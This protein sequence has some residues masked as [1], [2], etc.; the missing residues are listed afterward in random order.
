MPAIQASAASA[1]LCSGLLLA[2]FIVAEQTA[3]PLPTAQMNRSLH[4]TK[5]GPEPGAGMPRRPVRMP[6]VFPVPAAQM[7]R[8][9]YRNRMDRAKGVC[10]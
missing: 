7:N 5:A 3:E 2:S 10:H 4:V 8:S 9:L 1:V 6:A